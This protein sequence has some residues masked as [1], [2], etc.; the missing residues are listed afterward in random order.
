M[1]A[2]ISPEIVAWTQI[3]LHSYQRLMGR[4]LLLERVFSYI[5][6][7]QA[8]DQ[9]S[10]VVVSHGT[11]IDPILNYGNQSALNLWE[12]SW[13]E[14]IQTPSRLTAEPVNQG[15]RQEMLRQVAKTGF[16]DNYQGIRISKNGR[17]FWIDRAI[18]WNLADADGH[19]CGQAAT[20]AEWQ[21]CDK[22]PPEN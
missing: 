2:Q 17:R 9:A 13:D 22:N 8:L 15:I 1:S 12:M 18:V 7:A 16:I 11:Q 19:F 21:F 5:D 10:F 14:M 6:Q 20:F 3:L 4:D